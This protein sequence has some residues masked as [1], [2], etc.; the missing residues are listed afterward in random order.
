MGSEGIREWQPNTLAISYAMKYCIDTLFLQETRLN[1]MHVILIRIVLRTVTRS[2]GDT[3]KL[4]MGKWRGICPL[5]IVRFK[6]KLKSYSTSIS[7]STRDLHLCLIRLC[8]TWH[9]FWRLMT[10]WGKKRT[11]FHK[12]IVFVAHLPDYLSKAKI[13]YFMLF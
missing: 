3:L 4:G 6:F 1:T 8:W 5:K 9:F 12:N 13:S 2:V 7:Y 11:F 10:S